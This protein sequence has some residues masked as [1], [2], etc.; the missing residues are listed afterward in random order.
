VKVILVVVIVFVRTVLLPVLVGLVA[1]LLLAVAAAASA[2]SF[3]ALNPSGTAVTF[4][5]SSLST[6]T[7]ESPEYTVTTPCGQATSPRCGAQNDSMLQSC[8]GLGDLNNISVALT[9]GIDQL[10]WTSITGNASSNATIS[11]AGAEVVAREGTGGTV[12]FAFTVTRAG[13]TATAHSTCPVAVSS[14][15]AVSCP[16]ASATRSNRFPAT[17][18]PA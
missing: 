17:T 13:S 2:C 14:Q 4:D 1:V 5:L 6:A 9:A 11:L 10:P 12:P 16:A 7:Y 18:G 3:C 8:K 15:W